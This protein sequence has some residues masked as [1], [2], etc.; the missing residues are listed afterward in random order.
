MRE[1]V[2]RTRRTVE[3][4]L[5]RTDGRAAFL[6]S[7]LAYP[8]LYL[9]SLGHLSLD[10]RGY[11]TQMVADPLSRSVEAIR[12]FAYEPVAR[13]VVEPVDLLVSP[14]NVGLGV[15]LGVLVGLNVAV[16]VVAWRSPGACG[17]GRS[18]SAA[19]GLPA[20]VTGAACC[21]PGLLF[22]VGIQATGTLVAALGYATPVA[23]GLLVGSLLLVGGRR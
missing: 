18:A 21:G 20:L 1:R 9:A 3:D 4:A 22:V 2:G 14:L 13:V 23:F 17:V 8:L 19:A 7:A 11:A 10:G 12:P 5:G 15:A 16:T 6:A